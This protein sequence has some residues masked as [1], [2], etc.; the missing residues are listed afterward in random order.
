MGRKSKAEQAA[1]HAGTAFGLFDNARQHLAASVALL[2]DAEDEHRD[3]A[4]YHT[5]QAEQA[6]ADR[7]HSQRVHDRLAELLA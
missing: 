5:A 1:V 4:E 2:A 3:A 6:A 7:E